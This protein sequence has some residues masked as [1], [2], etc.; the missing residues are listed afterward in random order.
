MGAGMNIYAAR[1]LQKAL[2]KR[3]KTDNK[4]MLC[5]V[6]NGDLYYHNVF[7]ISNKGYRHIN[8]DFL[9]EL[10]KSAN[11]EDL[12][13]TIFYNPGSVYDWIPGMYLAE[14]IKID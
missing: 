1:K 2:Y 5:T 12:E 8:E 9:V 13:T 6:M 7:R 11:I 10:L 4:H 14:I 3:A